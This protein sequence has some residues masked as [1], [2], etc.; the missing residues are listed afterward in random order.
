MDKS[1]P[2]YCITDYSD[3]SHSK[4]ISW[5]TSINSNWIISGIYQENDKILIKTSVCS[6]YGDLENILENIKKYT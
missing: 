5:G 6:V 2:I 4:K 3:S 1:T